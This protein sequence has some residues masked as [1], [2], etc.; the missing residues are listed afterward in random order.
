MSICQFPHFGDRGFIS[1]RP[2]SL[3]LSDILSPLS[4]D[5]FVSC[6]V[7]LLFLPPAFALSHKRV[8]HGKHQA[9]PGKKR[10]GRGS[11]FSSFSSFSASPFSP[12]LPLSPADRRPSIKA[13]KKRRRERAHTRHQNSFRGRKTEPSPVRDGQRE[14]E[15]C[16]ATTKGIGYSRIGRFE[17]PLAQMENF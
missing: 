9:R 6:F 11:H 8:Q 7:A 16:Q 17:R 1:L 10:G 13:T 5:P 14:R 3:P 4:S 15:H 2:P 12:I